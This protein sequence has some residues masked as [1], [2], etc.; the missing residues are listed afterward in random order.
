VILLVESYMFHLVVPCFL[1]L[2]LIEI[3]GDGDEE[4][5]GDVE[6]DGD[7]SEEVD[8]NATQSTAS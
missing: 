4:F 3:D 1:S 7:G 2:S 5:S 8:V 6:V